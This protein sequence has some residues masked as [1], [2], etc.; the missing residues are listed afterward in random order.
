MDFVEIDRTIPPPE[1]MYSATAEQLL[2]RAYVRLCWTHLSSLLHSCRHG[3]M[4]QWDLSG[5][6]PRKDVAPRLC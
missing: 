4:S 6:V 1:L 2:I 5:L 3:T